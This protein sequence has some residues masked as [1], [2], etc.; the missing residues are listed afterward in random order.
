MFFYLLN[1]LAYFWKAKCRQYIAPP[2]FTSM[3]LASK[4]MFHQNK[5][6]NLTRH[7]FA[8]VDEMNEPN[9]TYSK[10]IISPEKTSLQVESKFESVL[11]SFFIH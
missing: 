3:Y 10:V 4:E 9:D 5:S 11:N 8:I 1:K 7:F 6:Q 2:T